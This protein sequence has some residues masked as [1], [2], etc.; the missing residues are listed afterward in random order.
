MLR[1]LDLPVY[2]TRYYI[3]IFLQDL[4]SIIRTEGRRKK[5]IKIRSF[6]E[7]LARN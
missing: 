2:N 1:N 5:K 4:L 6:I 3:P 7:P